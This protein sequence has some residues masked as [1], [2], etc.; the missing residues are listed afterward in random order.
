MT[1]LMRPRSEQDITEGGRRWVLASRSSIILLQEVHIHLD[2]MSISIHLAIKGWG[3][4]LFV[5]YSWMDLAAL[6]PAPIASITVAEP[7][8]M[9]PPAQT[10]SM[11]VFPVSGSAS[12]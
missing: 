12:M 1:G 2:L 5:R 7:V 4:A 10:P 3:Q 9:S 11:L 8:T 6:R